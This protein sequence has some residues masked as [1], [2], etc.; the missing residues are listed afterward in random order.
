M[1]P[2]I[3]PRV[4]RRAVHLLATHERRI[5]SRAG[6]LSG[7]GKNNWLKDIQAV[8]PMT[9]VP[10]WMISNYFYR[11][12]SAW[13]RYAAVPFLLLFN[14]GLLYVGLFL[15]DEF[16]V[17]S[18]PMSRG[19][20]PRPARA[21]RSIGG[22]L[23]RGESRSHR[24]PRRGLRSPVR[25]R[26]RR[27]QDPPPVRSRSLRARRRRRRGGSNCRQTG[28]DRG[29]PRRRGATRGD[30]IPFPPRD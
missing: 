12:M 13:L 29:R 6:R 21:G 2:V 19:G 18:L 30:R 24:S 1:P 20:R 16:G 7:R 28:A 23:P 9:R 4:L 8:T 25:V 26:P 5:T 27:S 14:L 22:P 11:E 17:W 15:L 10:D 3:L